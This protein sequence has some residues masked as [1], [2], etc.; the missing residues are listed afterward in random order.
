MVYRR[1][2]YG[3]RPKTRR[4]RRFLRSKSVRRF[5]RRGG[6]SQRVKVK[7]YGVANPFGD[8]AMVKL[9]FNYANYMVGDNASPTTQGTALPINDL[10][11]IYVYSNTMSKGYLTY[12]KL[13]RRYRVNGVMV[14]FTVFPY[15]N[16]NPTVPTMMFLQPWSD[17]EG[18]PTSTMRVASTL[19]QQRWTKTGYM[20][21]WAQGGRGTTISQFWKM[22]RLTGSNLTKTALQY[23]AITDVSGNPYNAPAEQWSFNYGVTS[24]A[25]L[26]LASQ[27]SFHYNLEVTYYVEFFEQVREQQGL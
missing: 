8:K 6:Q 4:L 22:S 12:P 19:K 26:V 24:V 2:R 9:K 27:Q 7:R 23:T 21:N 15:P 10:S 25:E 16:S 18:N 5:K 3:R 13:F 11:A 17:D 20:S 14:R 1:R